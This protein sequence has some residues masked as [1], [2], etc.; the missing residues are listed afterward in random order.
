MPRGLSKKRRKRL[1]KLE[2]LPVIQS[3][4]HQVQIPLAG[5]PL[6]RETLAD[7]CQE[8]MM[9]S[10]V[11]HGSLLDTCLFGHNHRIGVPVQPS[12]FC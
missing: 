10:K 8:F 4:H 9:Q 3:N 12:S 11:V 2:S 5:D 6:S 7:L 1:T